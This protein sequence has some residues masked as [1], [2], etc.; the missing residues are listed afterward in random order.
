MLIPEISLPRTAAE[1]RA[2]ARRMNADGRLDRER[3][4]TEHKAAINALIAETARISS[5]PRRVAPTAVNAFEVYEGRRAQSV[6]ANWRPVRTLPASVPR[7]QPTSIEIYSAR[8]AAS[9]GAR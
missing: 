5:Q 7:T 6:G 3:R 2:F 4:R 8:R 9:G 1:A